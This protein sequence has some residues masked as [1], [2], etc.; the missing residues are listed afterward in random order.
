MRRP[1]RD[2]R[3][4]HWPAACD[5]CDYYVGARIVPISACPGRDH[6]LAW[7]ALTA[8]AHADPSPPTRRYKSHG[9][10]PATQLDC[11]YLPSLGHRT[12]RFFGH[13]HGEWTVANTVVFPSPRRPVD[14][15]QRRGRGGSSDRVLVARRWITTWRRSRRERGIYP[16][17][18]P[19]LPLRRRPSQGP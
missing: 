16:A 2:Q 7:P 9:S 15:K 18:R 12:R 14:R 11:T 4:S 5:C 8:L 6:G 1:R 10:D 13:R 17:Q 19:R 3:P